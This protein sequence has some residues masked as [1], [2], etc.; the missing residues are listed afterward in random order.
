MKPFQPLRQKGSKDHDTKDQST[1]EQEAAHE[2][3]EKDVVSAAVPDPVQHKERSESADAP[4][5]DVEDSGL[6]QEPIAKKQKVVGEPGICVLCPCECCGCSNLHVLAAFSA[7]ASYE[8]VNPD[9][10]TI[11]QYTDFVQEVHRSKV[12]FDTDDGIP[13][14]GQTRVVDPVKTELVKS[15]ILAATPPDDHRIDVLTFLFG[16]F[17]YHVPVQA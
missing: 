4:A 16:V 10:V 6:T 9:T 14:H 7:E 8:Y 17:S 1:K 15:N 5:S 12:Q 3:V 11:Q 2:E 13:A